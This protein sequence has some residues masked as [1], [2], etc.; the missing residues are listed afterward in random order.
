[1]RGKERKRE[2][3]NEYENDRI[4]RRKEVKRK[5]NYPTRLE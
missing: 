5:L 1:M 4:D 2:R 3:N